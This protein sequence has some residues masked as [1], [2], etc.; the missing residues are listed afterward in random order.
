MEYENEWERRD[1]LGIHDQKQEGFKWIGAHVPVGRLH[2]EDFFE[3]A[4]LAEKYGNKTI[5]IT[6]DMHILF[7]DIPQDKVDEMLQEPFFEKFRIDPGPLERNLVSCTGSQFC[8]FALYETKAKAM[9]VVEKLET[10]LDFPKGVRIHFTGCPNS[11]GQAQVGEIGLMGAPAK[12][13]GKAVEGV[14]IFLGGKIGENP[15]LAK[16]FEK[17][18]PA[19]EDILLPK[20]REIL[21]NEFG[22]TPKS[23]PESIK[24]RTNAWWRS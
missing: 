7:T 3:A 11:C 23:N 14:K 2:A 13:N 4:E 10:E 8:G 6:C 16:E 5:R 1:L 22:A 15:K 19:Q 20:L 9:K 24:E 17:G 21:I 18:V 12:L